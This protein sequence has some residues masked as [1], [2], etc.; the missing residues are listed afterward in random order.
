MKF[1][2]R[3]Y[4][5]T[6]ENVISPI[7]EIRIVAMIQI[8]VAIGGHLKGILIR[9]ILRMRLYPLDYVVWKPGEI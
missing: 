7:F 8:I 2:A 9:Q 4:V 5:T 3:L 6:S 1:F